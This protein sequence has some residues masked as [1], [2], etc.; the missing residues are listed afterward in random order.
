MRLLILLIT[1]S[2]VGLSTAVLAEG[3][4][5]EVRS[6][7]YVVGMGAGARCFLKRGEIKDQKMMEEILVYSLKKRN[8][9]HLRGWMTTENAQMAIRLIESFQTTDCLV[10]KRKAEEAGVDE[11]LIR[12]ILDKGQ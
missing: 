11:A 1:A 6:K 8:L 5:P 7:L 12:L 4:T 2:V 3:L 10:D 9:F